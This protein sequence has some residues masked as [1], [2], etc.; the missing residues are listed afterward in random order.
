MVIEPEQVLFLTVYSELTLMRV[1]YLRHTLE[2]GESYTLVHVGL[3][4]QAGIVVIFLDISA[5]LLS[6]RTA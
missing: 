4:T 5:G 1:L 2:L 6:R 3:G